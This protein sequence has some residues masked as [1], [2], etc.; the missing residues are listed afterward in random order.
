M[1]KQ[2]NI[3]MDG[4]LEG[5]VGSAIGGANPLHGVIVFSHMGELGKHVV[6]GC[7]VCAEGRKGPI[8][9]IVGDSEKA[10][11]WP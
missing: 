5:G 6:L 8:N 2:Q 11:P 3:L 9:V 1:L 4:M 10:L 7:W